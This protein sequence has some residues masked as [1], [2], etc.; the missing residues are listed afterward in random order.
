LTI[1]DREEISVTA[2]ETTAIAVSEIVI[3]VKFTQN[4]T[5]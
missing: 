3:G 4:G 1:K 5:K 2:Y